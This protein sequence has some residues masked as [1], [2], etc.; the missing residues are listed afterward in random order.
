M[1]R[2][3]RH[4]TQRII[5]YAY[6]AN[7]MC[8]ENLPLFVRTPICIFAAFGK[9]RRI[10]A[11]FQFNGVTFEIYLRRHL[12][13]VDLQFN[14]RKSR[15]GFKEQPL[16][17]FGGSVSHT[18]ADPSTLRTRNQSRRPP[19]A[20]RLTQLYHVARHNL[21]RCRQTE[22]CPIDALRRHLH[23]ARTPGALYN[24]G[25]R[26]S[27]GMTKPM[28]FAALKSLFTEL[29]DQCV[30][31]GFGAGHH[32]NEV[33]FGCSVLN[34][35]LKPSKDFLGLGNL[36]RGKLN[37]SDRQLFALFLRHGFLNPNEMIIW[38]SL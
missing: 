26:G 27:I 1:S 24:A 11:D 36:L 18:T 28:F 6:F 12:L 32:A 29:H 34:I 9:K 35:L 15:N 37:F 31:H 4:F 8:R 33:L 13:N 14:R 17:F 19:A 21:C 23:V 22:L 3:N 25:R 30:R 7:K 10:G 2:G 20:D 5:H 38:P 16:D